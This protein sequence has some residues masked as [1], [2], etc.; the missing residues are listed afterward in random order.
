MPHR[1]RE[2]REFER[3]RMA[4]SAARAA[5]GSALDAALAQIGAAFDETAAISD[6]KLRVE[7]TLCRGPQH[8]AV[9]ARFGARAEA[10]RRL[11]PR[12]SDRA[13]GTLVARRTQSLPDRQ[14]AR[15]RQ[16]AVAGCVARVATHFA[17]VAVQKDGG[18]VQCD[19]CGGV[20]QGS[21]SNG[22]R[23]NSVG[24]GR[25][26]PGTG[27]H[28]SNAASVDGTLGPPPPRSLHL[29]RKVER[30]APIPRPSNRRLSVRARS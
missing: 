2:A 29:V 10:A 6:L 17:T 1:Q 8:P 7:R 14:R 20:R 26:Q 12:C 3:I 15:L 28:Q 18:G 27:S 21:G 19:C 23:I 13:R 5:T 4:A 9:R 30:S 16:P 24:V 22:R 11:E 25:N